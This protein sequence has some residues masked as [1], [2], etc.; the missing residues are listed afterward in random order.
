M[1]STGIEILSNPQPCAHIVY[2]YTDVAHLADAVCLFTSS[3]LRKGEAVVLVLSDPHYAPVRQRLEREGF[4]L[5]ALEETGQLVCA[6]AK[7]LL[8]NF[9]LDG[10]IDE[11]K[12]KTKIDRMI[13]R[14]KLCS[15]SRKH[16]PVRVFGEMVDLIWE[17]HP[18][19]TERLEE[20]WNEIIRIH[21]VPLLC[22][23]SLAGTPNALPQPLV[24]C[25]SHAIS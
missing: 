11:H 7:N 16:G 20:L 1:N 8:A 10:I 15:G 23:Y 4:E 17:P 3:G 6:N 2:S 19:A 9:M 13:E 25:H 14:A 18:R 24:A 5:A 22:A 12:F 21:S